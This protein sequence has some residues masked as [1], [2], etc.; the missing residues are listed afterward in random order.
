M[1]DLFKNRAFSA[2]WVAQASSALG[3]T[4]ATFIISW[5]VY[6]LSGSKMAMGSIWITFMVPSLLTTLLAGPYLD[7]FDRKKIMILSEWV[8]AAV[9]LVPL[10]LYPLGLL[11]VWHLYIVAATLGVA[12]PL[13]RPTS[14]AYVAQ[15]LPKDRLMKGNS[16]LEGTMQLMMLIGPALGGLLMS[17]LGV[18]PVLSFLVICMAVSGFVLLFIPSSKKKAASEKKETWF[19]QFKAGL[20]F[21]RIYPVLFWI[22][23]LLMI[24]NFSSGAAM[25]MFL[26]FVLD[27]LGGNEFQYGLFMSAFP[28]GMLLGSLVTGTFN[29]PKNLRRV[30]LGSLWMG[31][32][33]LALLGWVT[34][35]WMALIVVMFSGFFAMVFTINNTTFYQKRV[36]DEI[37]GRVFAVRTLLAQSG[38]PV[39]AAFGGL[40]AEMYSLTALFTLLGILSIITIT[41]AWFAKV[42]YHLNDEIEEDQVTLQVAVT[43]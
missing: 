31:G 16:L 2:V 43:K 20:K 34:T 30:M 40:F 24:S 11:N 15:I 36:P 18:V 29:Q 32:V 3:G 35:Y 14:M 33:L 41:I 10:I 6:E 42:F 37:R 39:G 12:E 25:P 19:V 28:L 7:R 17:V 9:F 21:Y 8:R 13:F 22:G 4:F 23:I 26:P 1:G 5:L 27:H 38:M